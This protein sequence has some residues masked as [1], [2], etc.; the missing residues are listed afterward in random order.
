MDWILGEE[1]IEF[2]KIYIKIA[3]FPKL[4]DED[5]DEFSAVLLQYFLIC[6]DRVANVGPGPLAEQGLYEGAAIRGLL[7][8]DLPEDALH[9]ASLP[10]S[11]GL[12]AGLNL[13][14]LNLLSAKRTPCKFR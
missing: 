5:P 4:F 8:E 6:A 13:Y 12:Q 1:C 9:C 14:H 10:I 3:T 2:H 7:A 11:S